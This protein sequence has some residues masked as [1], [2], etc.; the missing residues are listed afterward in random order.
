MNTPLSLSGDGDVPLS[1]SNLP[2][3]LVDNVIDH[4]RGD[5]VALSASSLTHSSM[6][7]RAQFHLFHTICFTP[8]R[9][10]EYKELVKMSPHLGYAVHHLI[11]TQPV[12]SLFKLES[13][14]SCSFIELSKP[15]AERTAPLFPAVTKLQ[16][17]RLDH[18][19]LF[20]P[21][22]RNVCDTHIVESI[23]MHICVIP[24]MAYVAEF[25]CSF[26]RLKKLAISDLFT[27][28]AYAAGR[29]KET[30]IEGPVPIAFRPSIE[31][32]RFPSACTLGEV[33]SIS[34]VKW[35]FER[36][37]HVHL[38]TLEIIVARQEDAVVLRMVLH[39]L[40]PRLQHLY[41]GV[42]QL[43]ED[44]S[45]SKPLTLSHSTSLRTFG[46]W[47]LKLHGDEGR[48]RP[49]LA[50]V[51]RL[52]MELNSSALE[53]VHFRLRAGGALPSDL[54]T[55]DWA[56]VNDILCEH[57][58]D[59]L[60]RVTIEVLRGHGIKDVLW[61]HVKDRIADLYARRTVLYTQTDA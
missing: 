33:N 40:G 13:Q 59:S 48:P 61:P 18:T 55:L 8:Q 53:H 34:M 45:F 39:Q 26:P 47:S 49:S 50:W 27:R 12:S 32:L 20:I 6:R 46:L 38:T 42:E 52:L 5:A 11:I 9:W 54:G 19:A 16:L 36:S 2:A 22:L 17:T 10:S 4:L 56:A 14:D 7:V 29:R 43:T 28:D 23:R 44:A 24:T 15:Q 3:E 37:M 30:S 51:P 41:L 21:L 35:L 1:F 31:V 58:F 57:R 60:R 25:I